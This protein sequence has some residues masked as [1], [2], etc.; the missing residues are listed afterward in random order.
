[1]LQD[2]TRISTR[3]M[4]VCLAGKEGGPFVFS[5]GEVECGVV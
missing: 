3:Y 4:D 2:V 5:S 1:M